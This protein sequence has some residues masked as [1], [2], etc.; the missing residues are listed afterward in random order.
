MYKTSLDPRLEKDSYEIGSI[1]D[2]RILLMRNALFPWFI[3]V[4]NTNE[5]EY[6]K[7]SHEQQSNISKQ[8]NMLSGFIEK[9][10]TIDKL[11]IGMIGNIVSQMHIHVIWRRQDDPCWP[12]VVW[13]TERSKA[14][15]VDQVEKI[16]QNFRTYTE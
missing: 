10:F 15:E 3:I 12:G 11:N 4:P 8:I 14:Y 9:Y 1:A 2:S 5:I 13:G 6:Y 16:K 7:L